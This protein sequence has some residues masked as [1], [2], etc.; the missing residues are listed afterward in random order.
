MTT[1]TVPTYEPAEI[2]KGE[3]L[4]W[5]KD[6][7]EY[8]AADGWTLTYYFRGVGA[9]F[10]ATATEASDGTFDVA[11]EEAV[12]DTLTAGAYQWEAWATNGTDT[13]RLATGRVTV[14]TSLKTVSTSTTIDRRS[15]AEIIVANIDA[16]MAGNASPAQK[17]Y[18]I[19]SGGA[20]R[21]LE[22]FP[23]SELISL[24]K[25][26]AGIANSEIRRA[27]A[28]AGGNYNRMVKVHF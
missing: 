19:G 20:E 13:V 7:T 17:A 11:V 21:R 5:T 14:I 23:P 26:Y 1:P 12:T 28:K 22:N 10:N 9:G 8:R 2:T 4:H 24:R 25:F 6:F 27:R 16:L 3:S 18:S 15:T